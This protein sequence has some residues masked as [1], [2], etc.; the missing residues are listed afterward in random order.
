MIVYIIILV[1]IV[2]LIVPWIFI[3]KEFTGS[4]DN[5]P[6]TLHIPVI[7]PIPTEILTFN[8]L[9]IDLYIE[10]YSIYLLASARCFTP[11]EPKRFIHPALKNSFRHYHYM[12]IKDEL[13]HSLARE[14]PQFHIRVYDDGHDDFFDYTTQFILTS[15]RISIMGQSSCYDHYYFYSQMHLI[16]IQHDNKKE[17]I[18]KLYDYYKLQKD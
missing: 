6:D 12:I 4:N 13:H 7:Q 10:D 15:R 3:I 11:V 5:V 8:N 16:E 2:V 9:I 1:G 14:K 18:K 17:L